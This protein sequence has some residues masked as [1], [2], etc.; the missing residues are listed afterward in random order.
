MLALRREEEGVVQRQQTRPAQVPWGAYGLKLW[1]VCE[2]YVA[3]LYLKSFAELRIGV[4]EIR[5]AAA[6]DHR[7]DPELDGEGI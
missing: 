3:R 1:V 5:Q 7:G 2:V 4:L 6:V